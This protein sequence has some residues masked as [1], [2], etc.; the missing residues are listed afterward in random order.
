MK[1]ID[2]R[3]FIDASPET[4]YNALTQQEGLAGWWTPETKATPEV[5]SIARFAFGPK[6]FKEMRITKLE[7]QSKVEW[8][9]V[10]GYEDWIGTTIKFEL[11]AE[12]KGT[13]LTLHHEGWKKYTDG[14][15]ACS[16]DWAMFLRSMRLLC[17]TGKGRPYPDFY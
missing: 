7:P 8:V 6:Y 4:V 11:E 3:L 10:K 16:Y 14:V 12:G 5:D 15:G 2:H 9:C 13:E 1:S 17:E